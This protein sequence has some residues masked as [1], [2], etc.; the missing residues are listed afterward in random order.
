MFCI[1]I[2]NIGGTLKILNFV[3]WYAR[4]KALAPLVQPTVTDRN[5][6]YQ[7][8]NLPSVQFHVTCVFLEST[9]HSFLH[10]TGQASVRPR[11]DC[12]SSVCVSSFPVNVLQAPIL[13]Y[14]LRA[15]MATFST[16][17]PQIPIHTQIKY[18]YFKIFT[19]TVIFTIKPTHFAL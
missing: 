7:A 2:K 4:E 14:F 19:V 10:P 15:L 6:T 3:Q 16:E 1:E 9:F 17:E 12:P 18:S 5:L 11:N 13:N 8:Y